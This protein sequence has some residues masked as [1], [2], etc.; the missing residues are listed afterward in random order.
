MDFSGFVAF[1]PEGERARFASG[2]VVVCVP[3]PVSARLS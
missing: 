2:A 1:P 3:V